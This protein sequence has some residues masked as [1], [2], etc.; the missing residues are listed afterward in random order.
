MDNNAVYNGRLACNAFMHKQMNKTEK[1]LSGKYFQATLGDWVAQEMWFYRI[2][3]KFWRQ[4]SKGQLEFGLIF[5]TWNVLSFADSLV[6]F[7]VIKLAIS[8]GPFHFERFIWNTSILVIYSWW[9]S[10]IVISWSWYLL[11]NFLCSRISLANIAVNLILELFRFFFPFLCF[12][13]S[14]L[15]RV[16]K[17]FLKVK[18]K[19][20]SS[21]IYWFSIKII[22]RKCFTSLRQQSTLEIAYL[23]LSAKYLHLRGSGWVLLCNFLWDGWK[24]GQSKSAALYVCWFIH[25]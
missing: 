15:I 25:V 9:I 11:P 10:K 21:W 17:V 1:M 24:E 6:N 2:G 8:L 3:L 23:V 18:F 14:R 22:E 20:I 13:T 4:D 5:S 12:P 7:G 19:I 16:L